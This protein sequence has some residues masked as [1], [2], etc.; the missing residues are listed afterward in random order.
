[1][2][3]WM[4]AG[5]LSSHK[6]TRI[7]IDSIEGFGLPLVQAEIEVKAPRKTLYKK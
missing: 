2:H 3:L 6:Q 5:H 4:S 1:M 7:S